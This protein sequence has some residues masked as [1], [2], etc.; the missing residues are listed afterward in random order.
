MKRKHRNEISGLRVRL[1]DF[2]IGSCLGRGNRVLA[3][4]R[5]DAGGASSVDSGR[6]DELPSP[7]QRICRDSRTSNVLY[8][9][10]SDSPYLG[11][12]PV[13]IVR[14][15]DLLEWRALILSFILG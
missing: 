13:R 11:N 15:V 12:A 3:P 4:A 7:A 2:L 8:C 10:Q 5:N 14:R 1:G 9:G 6:N